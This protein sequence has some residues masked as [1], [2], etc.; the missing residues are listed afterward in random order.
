[1]LDVPVFGIILSAVP[2]ILRSF[3]KKTCTFKYGVKR[4]K[5]KDKYV[6]KKAV[7]ELFC[8]K[9]NSTLVT[10]FV[11]NVVRCGKNVWQ[12]LFYDAINV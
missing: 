3:R 4:L 8:S 2:W 11:N 1:M 7:K 10:Q 6:K 9:F 12:G 5:N